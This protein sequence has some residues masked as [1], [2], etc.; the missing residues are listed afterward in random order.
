MAS[1]GYHARFTRRDAQRY[2]RPPGYVRGLSELSKLMRKVYGTPIVDMILGPTRYIAPNGA[3][4]EDHRGLLRLFED[5]TPLVRRDAVGGRY[6]EM[7]HYLTLT[8]PS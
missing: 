2:L 4:V 5:D 1:T 6:I 7:A 3:R 8:P